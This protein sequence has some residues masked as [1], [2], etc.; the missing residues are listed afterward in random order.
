MSATAGTPKRELLIRIGEV[1]SR[2][3]EEFPDISISKIRFLEDEGLISPQRTRGGYRLFS[4]TDLE[5]LETILRL[6]RDEFLPLRVI[7][8]ELAA[9]GATERKRRRPTGVGERPRQRPDPFDAGRILPEGRL[10]EDEHGWIHR[11]DRGQ[12][13][14]LSARQAEVVRVHRPAVGQ[15]GGPECDLDEPI[16]RR[17]VDAEVARPEPDLALDRPLEQL[18]V[19]M[20]EDESDRGGQLG[21]RRVGDRGAVETDF[22]GGRPEQADEMLHERRLARPVAAD[23]R[24]PLAGLDP[25]VDA[26]DR[27]G[28]FPVGMADVSELD[29]DRGSIA[30]GGPRLRRLGRRAAGELEH[31]V[32]PG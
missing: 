29:R 6:Q 5:R 3:R 2:L 17:R 24:D 30:D 4:E 25:E 14:Q 26:A 7:R 21:D 18:I 11:Q 9:P 8:E 19:G 23:D 13:D 12:R 28:P 1:V 15:A 10:V 27:D 20:L 31:A 16:G 32:E 22:A